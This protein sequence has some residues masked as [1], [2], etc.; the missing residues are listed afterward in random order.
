MSSLEAKLMIAKENHKIENDGIKEFY[1]KKLSSTESRF[2]KKKDDN[3][4]LRA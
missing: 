4:I 3:Q 1:G 2:N